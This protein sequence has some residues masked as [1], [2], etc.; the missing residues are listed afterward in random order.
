MAASMLPE[1]GEVQLGPVRLPEGRRVIPYEHDERVAWVTLR[2]VQDPGLAWSALTDLHGETGLVPVVLNDDADDYDDLFMEPC[3]VGEID[4]LDV[5]ELLATRWEGDLEDDAD[6]DPMP[7]VTMPRSN[8]FFGL[9][10]SG[11]RSVADLAKLVFGI[12]KMGENP[13]T[14]DEFE[15]LNKLDW[16]DAGPEYEEWAARSRER[17]AR[18]PKVPFPGLAPATDGTTADLSLGQLAKP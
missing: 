1:N 15:R 5:S 14:R 10:D 2:T 11:I 8:E 18:R 9:K 6:D 17:E 16:E 7:P 13:E 3:D 4:R 12:T